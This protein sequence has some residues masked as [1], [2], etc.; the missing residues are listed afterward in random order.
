M[1]KPLLNPV[2]LLAILSFALPSAAQTTALT[3]AN[4]VDV[5]TGAVRR[6]QTII[7]QRTTI[8]SVGGPQMPIPRG[9]RVTDLRGGYVI[10]GLWDMHAHLAST[11]RSALALY[12][13]NG[14]TGV[15]DMGSIRGVVRP[16]RDSIEAG[17]LIGP[18][19]LLAGPII[20]R[21][22]WLDA[23]RGFARQSGDSGLIR[24]MAERIPVNT[25]VTARKAVDSVIALGADFLK[26][27][28]DPTPVA[29]YALLR[30]ARERNIAVAGHWPSAISPA[31]ASDSGFRSVEHGALSRANGRLGPTLERMS[32]AERRALFVKFARN[33]TAYTPTLIS[34][35][36]FRLTP[37]SVIAKVLSDSTGEIDPR[38]RYLDRSLVSGWKTSFELKGR[39]TPPLDWPAF[40]KSWNHD[41]REMAEAKVLLLAGTDAASPLVFTGFAVAE[42]LEAMVQE[43]G[44]TPLQSLQ[45]ATVNV[46]K[47]MNAEKSFGVVAAGRRGDLT[48][49]DGNPLE[50]IRN[51]A[52]VRAVVRDGRV[53]DRAALDALLRNVESAVRA[54]KPRAVTLDTSYAG[55]I[56]RA[57]GALDAQQWS[58]GIELFQKAL[59]VNPYVADHWFGLGRAFYNSN[60]YKESVAPFER[61]FQ[62]G[63]ARRYN[64]AWN[65]A[66][67][68][69]YEGQRDEA[70]KWLATS[71]ELGY[72]SREVMRQDTAFE[73]Y[74][75]D[76]RF[77]ELTDSVDLTK[78]SKADGRKHDVELMIAEVRR[79]HRDP[80]RTIAF[81]EFERRARNL[82]P[83]LGALTENEF[84]VAIQRLL[85]TLGSA[86]SGSVPEAIPSWGDK[87]VPLQFFDFTDGLRI[88]AADSAYA[89]LVGAQVTRA[90]SRDLAQVRAAIDSI[91][92][93]DHPLGRASFTRWLRYPQLLNGLGI[94][95]TSDTLP[96]TVIT[97]AG[98]T[99][100]IK[101]PVRSTGTGYL[102]FAGR[103]EWIQAH[104][105][106]APDVPLYLQ[107]RERAYS[108]TLLPS[109]R[110]LYFQFNS[111]RNAG[112]E[113]LEIFV[114]RMFETADSAG[115]QRLVI[116]LR[117][118][119]GG[120][121]ALLTPLLR[122][123]IARER[124]VKRGGLF[125]IIGRIT[126]SA[127]QNAVTL[128]ERYVSPILVGEVTASSPNFVGEDN[129]ITLPYSRIGVSIS[130]LYWQASW[131]QD[132]RV[133]TA[134]LLYTPPTWEAY[135]RGRDPAMEAVAGYGR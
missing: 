98:E 6:D 68:Y 124:F 73:K 75:N 43:A 25:P 76:P 17:K 71:L 12:L 2:G 110:T 29:L 130:D 1:S 111:V 122:A 10:P 60:R 119:Y 69:A 49:L 31:E 34:L 87:A 94:N 116:D 24:D 77:K 11:G 19:I 18:R 32:P 57:Y 22:S 101:V 7:L 132:E 125:V 13:A 115:A 78:L 37:D 106:L 3:H 83:R 85:A 90:G 103:P 121:T 14:V 42:E 133:W 5:E 86:H 66:R 97:S 105:K 117:W 56:E 112:D 128:L 74:R 123:V 51:V 63:A 53:F 16:W 82:M 80:N 120:N 91:T 61:A 65:I 100:S 20:E 108:F 79:M 113:P 96:L 35:K 72:R 55:I 36:G 131:P 44:L 88:V 126:N 27:R 46:A 107:N 33:G 64:T 8:K 59:A 26:I 28:N 21:T 95:P 15:R 93:K 81:A 40:S 129:F 89:D 134:P 109:Q 4:V 58:V 84:A 62:L 118:N 50:D 9:A 104:M 38:I 102:R 92:S 48:V 39:E 99:R 41:L 30:R 67:A 114:Q 135:R 45:T 52:R 47:W 70:M 54:S 23:V 127:A